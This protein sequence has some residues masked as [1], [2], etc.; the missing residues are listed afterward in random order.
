MAFLSDYIYDFGLSHLSAQGNRVDICST[1]PTTYSAATST[2]SLGY[3]TSIVI[4]SPEDGD[5]SGRKVTMTASS[6]TV[7][8]T[9]TA[10]HFA[11]TDTSNSR[12]LV[13]GTLTASQIVTTG[14][15][16]TLSALDVEIPDPA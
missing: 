2:N 10:T 7:T 6:G 4:N 16:F 11:I 9:G 15:E 13:S 12:L 5:V 1:E 14:N 8:G 3:A